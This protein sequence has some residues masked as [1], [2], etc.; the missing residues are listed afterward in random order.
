MSIASAI[1]ASPDAD[2]HV[3]PGAA[4][5][6]PNFARWELATRPQ[7]DRG[8]CSVFAVAGA[9]EHALAQREDRG[10]LL[11]VEFLNWAGHRA[12]GRTVDGG[13][14]WELWN[15][16][17]QFG[18]CAEDDLPYADAFDADLQPGQT[19]LDAAAKRRGLAARL[20]WIKEWV[21]TTGLTD[22]EFAAI[23]RT[24]TDGAPVCGGFRWPKNAQWDDGLLRMA[25]AAE[26]FDGHSV[27]LSG[28]VDDG[29]VP[30]GG[31]FSIRNSAAAGANGRMSYE[32]VR[33]YMNDAAWIEPA[34]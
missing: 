27:L 7:G 22:D 18:I 30:G 6:S 8:T 33:E 28:Y 2:R 20:H 3:L 12:T 4:D 13:F 31:S 21:P 1:D 23:K 16:Y 34:P 14:F 15:G 17:E 25:P 11:S 26:V 24:L 29:D 19:V 32:Y 9:L 10:T 5:L